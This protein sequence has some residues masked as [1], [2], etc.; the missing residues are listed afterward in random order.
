MRGADLGAGGGV[1][2]LPLLVGDDDLALVLVDAS[3]KR[4]SFCAWAVAE[5]G[6]RARGEVWTGRAEDFAND[7]DRRGSFDVVVARGFGPPPVTLECAAPLLRLGGWC[8]ISEPPEPRPWPGAIPELGL[9]RVDG[10]DG[11]A[12]FARTGPV[13]D[14]FPRPSKT[15]KRLP[16][17]KL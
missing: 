15:Q 16:L 4:M 2:A 7:E 10:L 8:V 6:V 5:L 3:Q 12:V 11:V 1:P 17:F 14:E 9:A 13:G